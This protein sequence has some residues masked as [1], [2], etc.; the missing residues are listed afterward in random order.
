M[1]FSLC[2]LPLVLPLGTTEESLAL[3]ALHSSFRYLYTLI[4]L[5]LWAFS[6]TDCMVLSPPA[7]FQTRDALASSLLLWSFAGPPPVYVHVCLVL[8]SPWAEPSTPEISLQC[9]AGEKDHLFGPLADQEDVVLI[10]HSDTLL[11]KRQVTIM[12]L[13]LILIWFLNWMEGI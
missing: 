3:S 4:R 6:S 2:S 12:V 1:C 13:I 9:S 5:P 10:C 8:V 7:F 11:E